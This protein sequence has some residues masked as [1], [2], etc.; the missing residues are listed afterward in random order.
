MQSSHRRR[1]GTTIKL[2][3]A[4]LRGVAERLGYT[5]REEKLLRE[6]GYHVR[7][8]GCVVKGTKMIFLD[9]DAAAEAQLDVLVDVL[10]GE[11]LEDIF[12]SPQARELFYRRSR[13]LSGAN[14]A[15]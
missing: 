3:V 15:A 14:E 1:S 4:E 5:V 2:L 10:A 13:R 11:P 8:G 6:V 7:G 12:L 9:R